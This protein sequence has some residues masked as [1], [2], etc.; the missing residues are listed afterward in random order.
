[1][2]RRFSSRRQ[3]LSH[4]FLQ[5]RLRGARAYRR[6]AGFFRSS[7]FELAGVWRFSF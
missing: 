7:V 1:M 5:D 6:I 3:Q 2:L 4:T